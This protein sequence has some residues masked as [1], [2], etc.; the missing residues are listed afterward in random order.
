MHRPHFHPHPFPWCLRH[1][2]L[3]ELILILT[4]ALAALMLFHSTGML[5]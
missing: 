3:V 2:H 5:H 4:G 1:E